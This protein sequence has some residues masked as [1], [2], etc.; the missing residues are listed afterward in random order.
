MGH[1]HVYVSMD[2]CLCVCACVCERACVNACICVCFVVC[3]CSLPVRLR[4]CEY[5]CGHARVYLC[6]YGVLFARFCFF[7]S[8]TM[9][10]SHHC[11][12]RLS[13]DI[14]HIAAYGKNDT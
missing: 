14:F 10:T 1:V 6:K 8:I 7:F 5:A 4:V 11:F 12:R 2:A 9:I 3:L 13:S